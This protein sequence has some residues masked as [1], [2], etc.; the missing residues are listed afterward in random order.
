MKLAVVFPGQGSQHVG[1]GRDWMNHAEARDV[2]EK[3]ESSLGLLLSTLCFDGP[4]GELRLTTNTQPAIL[5]TSIAI[6]C[7][8]LETLRLRGV[9]FAPAYFAGHSLG[10]YTALVAAESLTVADALI[11]VR[12]RGRLMQAAVPPGEGAMAAVI[13]LDPAEIGVINREIAS[14]LNAVLDIANFNSPDQT[15]VSGHANAVAEALPRYTAAGAKRVAELPVSAPFHSALMTP[16]ADGLKPILGSLPFKTPRTPVISNLAVQPYPE[17]P[18]QYHLLLH[19]QI[20][21]PVRWVETMQYFAA[22]GVTHLLE[23]GP[24]KVLRMLAVKTNRELSSM[25]IEFEA[26]LDGLVAWLQGAEAA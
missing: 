24:G 1:M 20:F 12:E 25:N 4:E 26:E 8:L 13:G 11:T 3:A 7:S 16:A 10:E 18:A 19:A 5:A 21:N 14:E 22:Q 6:Y 9:E 23:V 17:D 15:V 2:F